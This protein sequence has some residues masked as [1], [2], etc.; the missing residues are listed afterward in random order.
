[1]AQKII[2][3]CYIIYH[4]LIIYKLKV[5]IF[6]LFLTASKFKLEEIHLVIIFE[7]NSTNIYLLVFNEA[8][9]FI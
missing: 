4:L 6:F 8:I 9:I 5:K 3:K 7:L 2:C 1:M